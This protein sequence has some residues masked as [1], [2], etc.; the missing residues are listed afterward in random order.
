[1]RW[2]LLVFFSVYTGLHIIFY[3]SARYLL[4]PGRGVRLIAWAWLGLMILG[5]LLTVLASMWGHPKASGVIGTVAY[6][7]MAYLLISLLCLLG[8]FLLR[9]LAWPFAR[10]PWSW[11]RPVALALGAALILTAYAGWSATQVRLKRVEIATAKLPAGLERLDIAVTSDLHL[12]LPG[13]QARLARAIGLIRRARPDLWIDAGD[14][15]DRPLL[16]ARELTALMAAVRPPLGKYAVGGN[17]ETYVGL[18]TAMSLDRAAGFVFLDDRGLAVGRAL[19]LAGVIDTRR[20]EPQ[21]DAAALRGLDLSRFTLLL[22]HRPDFNPATRGKI[23]LQV[24][25][26]THGGQVWPFHY[27]VKNLYPLFTGLHDL[28]AGTLVYTSRGTGLWGPPIRLFAPPEV[29]LISLVR[30]K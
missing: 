17:H 27:V 22:R 5:P 9:L 25:G 16:E 1:M 2:F 3:R 28:G 4:P 12:G 19:N 24:S 21:R 15:W 11:R 20:P 10:E 26:H 7:W 6:W 30:P 14:M 8:L 18:A 23:D 29:T 13:G